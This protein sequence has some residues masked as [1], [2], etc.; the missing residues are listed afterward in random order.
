MELDGVE[1]MRTFAR[2]MIARKETTGE[3]SDI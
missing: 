3:L 2:G 1:R